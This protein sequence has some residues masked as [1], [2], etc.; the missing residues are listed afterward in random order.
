MQPES[1]NQ[2]E[3]QKEGEGSQSREGCKTESNFSESH[4]PFSSVKD[5]DK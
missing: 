4:F 1:W 3:V 5:N 2:V